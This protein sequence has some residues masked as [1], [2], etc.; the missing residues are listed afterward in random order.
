MPTHL[1]APF[2]QVRVVNLIERPDRRREMENQF[3]RIGAVGPNV[4]F[5]DA[6]RPRDA[7]EFPSLGARGCFESHFEILREAHAKG[8]DS[9]LVMED[10]FDFTRD[11][12]RRAAALF[13]Q[14]GQT[15]WDIFYGAHLLAPAERRELARVPFDEPVLT[16]SF[17]A[18]HSRVLTAIIDFLGAIANRPSGSPEFGPMHVDGAYTVFR[19]MHPRVLTF[20]AFPPLGQQRHSRPEITPSDMLLDQLAATRAIAS[21]LRAAF[22]WFERR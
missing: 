15:K 18:F 12:C 8:V 16:A 20:A 5:F 7:G 13:E 14:L 4:S 22:N 1:F 11:G 2:G 6:R 10:D 9:V 17:V 19:Q 21:A 3:K